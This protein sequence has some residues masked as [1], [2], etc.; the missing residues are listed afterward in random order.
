MATTTSALKTVEK[1]A[2]PSKKSK[3]ESKTEASTPEN[4]AFK[5]SGEKFDIVPPGAEEAPA[6]NFWEEIEKPVDINT[7][8]WLAGMI[9]DINDNPSRAFITARSKDVIINKIYDILVGE[10]VGH[11]GSQYTTKTQAI[12]GYFE[13]YEK[14][15]LFLMLCPLE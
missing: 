10:N 7:Y 14:R 5:E 2:K 12:R 4:G 9:L 15:D 1:E 6:V 8:V 3:V 13:G 11:D